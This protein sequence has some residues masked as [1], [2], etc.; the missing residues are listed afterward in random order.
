M[1]VY[2]FIVNSFQQL[3]LHTSHLNHDTAFDLYVPW[4]TTPDPNYYESE[5]NRASFACFDWQYNF[6]TTK[7]NSIDCYLCYYTNSLRTEKL[8]LTRRLFKLSYRLSTH[9]CPINVCMNGIST[10]PAVALSRLVNWLTTRNWRQDLSRCVCGWIGRPTLAS[11]LLHGTRTTADVSGLEIGSHW[12]NLVRLMV[13]RTYKCKLST[14]SVKDVAK[15]HSDNPEHSPLVI[16]VSMRSK[17]DKVQA[18]TQWSV[19]QQ[20]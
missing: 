4:L 3:W 17:W 7:K 12:K 20:R 1:F 16:Y 13:A 9:T 2:G 18:V 6:F 8:W 10:C 15:S 14:T 11:Q 19:M 5:V